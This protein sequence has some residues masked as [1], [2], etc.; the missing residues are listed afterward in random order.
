MRLLAPPRC[1]HCVTLAAQARL[2]F[3]LPAP[4]AASTVL[5][6]TVHTALTL[7]DEPSVLPARLPNLLINGSSGIAVGIATKIPPH[8]MGEVGEGAGEE[9]GGGPGIYTWQSSG[10]AG[11]PCNRGAAC[12]AE[13]RLD[14][15]QCN[16]RSHLRLHLP[17][18]PHYN[19]PFPPFLP[20]PPGPHRWCLASRR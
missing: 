16:R 7:Q 12:I 17:L 10:I 14:E 19:W 5:L 9:K 15:M 6:P 1:E 11:R 13:A 4:P 2:I 8:N 18:H 20:R 3:L